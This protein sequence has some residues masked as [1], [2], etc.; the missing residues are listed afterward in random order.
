[1]LGGQPAWSY[2]YCYISAKETQF[3]MTFGVRQPTGW[4]VCV[5]YK[6]NLTGGLTLCLGLLC[7]LLLLDCLRSDLSVHVLQLFTLSS[8]HWY[9]FKWFCVFL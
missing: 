4:L 8:F 9:G 1:M 7:L 2:I 6:F 3:C 5:L